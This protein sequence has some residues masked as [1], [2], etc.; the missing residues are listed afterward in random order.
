ML[1]GWAA[2]EAQHGLI[3]AAIDE[4]RNVFKELQTPALMAAKSIGA[5]KAIANG[6]ARA[7]APVAI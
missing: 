6:E 5:K 2:S 1:L 7:A 4:K 3:I